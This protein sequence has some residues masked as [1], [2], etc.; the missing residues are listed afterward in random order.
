MVKE[1]IIRG[2]HVITIPDNGLRF[3]FVARGFTKREVNDKFY[4]AINALRRKGVKVWY[5][6]PKITNVDILPEEST[7]RITIKGKGKQLVSVIVT[8][9]I[10]HDAITGEV[11]VV[12]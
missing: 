11:V 4:G 10:I 8:N 12:K 3:P 6:K 9:P 1:V 7:E 5:E 2:N